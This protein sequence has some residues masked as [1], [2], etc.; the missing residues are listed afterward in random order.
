M[1]GTRP[2]ARTLAVTQMLVVA[3]DVD[4]NYK[5]QPHLTRW[6]RRVSYLKGALVQDQTVYPTSKPLRQPAGLP[7]TKQ[8]CAT[9]SRNDAR[10]ATFPGLASRV[11]RPDGTRDLARSAASVPRS[12][13]TVAS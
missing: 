6:L 8:S 13:T 4:G 11:T 10:H 7:P 3:V 2:P 1:R 5:I 12:T 9:A